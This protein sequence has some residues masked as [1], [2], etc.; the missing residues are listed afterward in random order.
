MCTRAP[1]IRLHCRL[2]IL[3]SIFQFYVNAH[4]FPFINTGTFSLYLKEAGLACRNIVLRFTHYH[5]IGNLLSLKELSTLS[6]V[7]V[8]I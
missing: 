8:L 2:R 7:V 5:R 3:N 4:F 6:V 1:K